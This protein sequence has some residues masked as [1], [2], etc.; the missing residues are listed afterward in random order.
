MT[1]VEITDDRTRADPFANRRVA[2]NTE[3]RCAA[4]DAT[5]RPLSA[6]SLTSAALWGGIVK[7]M[8]RNWRRAA[9]Q[10]VRVL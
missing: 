10:H 8:T 2:G 1:A 5:G 4:F 3:I 6:M 7:A 9:R